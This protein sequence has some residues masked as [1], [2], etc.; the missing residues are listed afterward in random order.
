MLERNGILYVITI[1]QECVEDIHLL[2][3]NILRHAV[4]KY[5]DNIRF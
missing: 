3:Q 2:I 1:C 4:E 5:S